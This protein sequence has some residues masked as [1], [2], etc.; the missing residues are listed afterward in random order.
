V[1]PQSGPD[2]VQRLSA[3]NSAVHTSPT[4]L[5]SEPRPPMRRNSHVVRNMSAQQIQG[6]WQQARALGMPERASPAALVRIGG[7]KGM[8]PR[9]VGS[10]VL[11]Q[12]KKM[13]ARLHRGLS[14]RFSRFDGFPQISPASPAGIFSGQCALLG[15]PGMLS[16]DETVGL[17]AAV[18]LFGHGF[19][20]FCGCPCR[21]L[22]P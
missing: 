15:P 11:V 2:T 10:I 20:T 1:A 6:S 7:R 5:A 19:D 3:E 17:F 21:L 9:Q 16:A 12:L 13:G 18:S 8:P 4:P 22:S 14:C